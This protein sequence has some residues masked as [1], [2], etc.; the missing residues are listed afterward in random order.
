MIPFAVPLAEKT[1]IAHIRRMALRER[2]G[3]ESCPTHRHRRRLCGR[4]AAAAHDILVTTDFSLEGVSFRRSWHRRICWPSMLS[5]R[6]ERHRSHG[7]L[8]RRCFCH[9]HCGGV[10]QR[11][12]ERFARG[13]LTLARNYGAPLAGGDTAESP[14]GILADIVVMGTVREGR[15]L[16]VRGRG[17][18]TEYMSAVN[19]ADLLLPWPNDGK[20]KGKLNPRIILGISF[21]NTD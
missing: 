18:V 19:S 6:A 1:L 14:H 16:G 11:W 5:A 17:L 15:P 13:L 2:Q 7:G 12:V 10:A 21:P 20:G 9:S 8:R 3:R 4:A